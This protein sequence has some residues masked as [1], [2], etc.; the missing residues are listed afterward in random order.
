MIHIRIGEKRDLGVI[1]LSSRFERFPNEM[2]DE[3]I[4]RIC[5]MKNE[6]DYTWEEIADVLNK[7]L[8]YE[9]TSSKY[10]KSYQYFQ[11]MFEANKHKYFDGEMIEEL[12][13][14]QDDLYKQEIRT[15]DW[16]NEKRKTLRDEARIDMLKDALRQPMKVL[17]RLEVNDD[18]TDVSVDSAEAVLVLSDWH[19]GE[20]VESFFNNFNKDIFIKRIEYLSSQVLKYCK[21]NN[22]AI[23]NVLNLNDLISGNIHVSNRVNESVNLI[24]QVKYVS[25]TMANMLNLFANNIRFVTYRSST[26]NHSRLNKSYEEHI[27][28]ENLTKLIDWWLEERLSG[29]NVEIK[30]DNLSDDLGLIK[31]LNGK[32]VFFSH[33]HNDSIS[34]SISDYS[35]ATGIRADYVILGHYHSDKATAIQGCKVYVNGSLIGSNNFALSKRLFSKPSQMLLIFDNDNEIDIRINMDFIK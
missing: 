13:T 32:I 27:E 7:N 19:Y 14:K 3:Y 2:E 25:E 34:S 15:R 12:D 16:L 9:F 28:K 26:D 33:G 18:V 20:V 35:L 22:V 10:R 4:F 29:T 5:D 8:G 30:N 23:L 24:E 6:L 1:N 11:K 21:R 31:L 17:P